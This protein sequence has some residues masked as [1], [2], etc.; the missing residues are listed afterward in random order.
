MKPEYQQ[1]V[2]KIVSSSE[3]ASADRMRDLLIYLAKQTEPA[4]ETVIGAEVFGRDPDYDP[5]TD[6]IVRSEVRRLRSKF[7][8]LLC[9]QRYGRY[10]P[11]RDPERTV[12]SGRAADC[13]R[14]W[15]VFQP[16]LV[17]GRGGGFAR[18]GRWWIVAL[19]PPRPI[20]QRRVA[21]AD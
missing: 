13:R 8:G 14:A 9:G 18:A 11:A 6:G 10:T 16:A 12:C 15:K 7:A 3:F 20:P 4:K 5:K 21:S 1:W 17:G 2:E 19:G